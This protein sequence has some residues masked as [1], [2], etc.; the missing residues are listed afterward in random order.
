VKPSTP[1]HQTD[2]LA[3]RQFGVFD[4]SQALARGHTRSSIGTRLERGR[5]IKIHP[6][7]YAVAGSPDTWKRRAMAGQ[8][9]AGPRGGLSHLSAA[10]LLGINDLHPLKIDVSTPRQIAGDG[11]RTHRRLLA[12]VNYTRMSSFVLTIPARTLL[13][14]ASVLDS[15]RLEDSLEECLHRR[16]LSLTSLG[17]WLQETGSQGRR[18]GG[19]L[20]ALINLR[21][22]ST[23]PTETSFETLLQR[24]LRKA[25]LPLPARQLAVF[26]ERGFVTRLDFAYSRERLGIPADSYIWHARRRNWERDI[27]QR[28]RLLRLGWRL[29]PTTWTELKRRPHVFT[30]DI[31]RLLATAA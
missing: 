10:Y 3:A 25:G 21:D 13:D 14:L 8:L 11:V 16:L 9:L 28:N 6:G 15:D 5:W 18:G 17:K 7:V 30:D 31:A 12:G 2:D 1:D 4:R 27:E 26:D 24:V 23:T 22:P 20:K 29:R 19:C